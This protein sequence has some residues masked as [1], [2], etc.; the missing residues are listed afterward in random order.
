[1]VIFDLRITIYMRC[2]QAYLSLEKVWVPS[3]RYLGPLRQLVYALS[4]PLCLLIEIGI[5][6]LVRHLLFGW[7]QRRFVN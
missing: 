7:E 1:M 3:L 6:I 2:G 5:F 4:V